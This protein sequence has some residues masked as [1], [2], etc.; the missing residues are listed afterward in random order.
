VSVARTDRRSVSIAIA[1]VLCILGIV[2][3]HAWTG[4]PGT[5][6]AQMHDTAQG[7]LRWTLIELVGRAAVPLLGAISGWL[8]AGSAA[9]RGWGAFMRGKLRAITVP[10]LAWN[11]IAM[12][13]VCG[14][15]LAGWIEAPLPVSA[16]WVVDELTA[17]ATPND[18]NVQM[19]FLRDLIVCMALAPLLARL[20]AAAVMA[21]VL[22]CAA[23]SVSGVDFPLLLR[24]SIMVFFALGMLVHRREPLAAAIAARAI[25]PSAALYLLLAALRVGAQVAVEDPARDWPMTVATFDLVMRT[26]ACVFFWQ[27]AWRL[28]GGRFAQTLQALEPYVFLTFCA[29]LVLIW[30]AAPAVGAM[31]GPLGAPLYPLFLILQPPLAMAG[32]FLIGR[33]LHA[34]SPALAGVLSGGRLADRPLARA[35]VRRHVTAR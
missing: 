26:V 11:A 30:L 6:L 12:V 28:A 5:Q 15:A 9:R 10:M 14:A 17:I 25:A 22:A 4:L 1:R 32:C 20:P 18:I 21:V 2:Y 23:W 3:V 35:P 19:P 29:H 34:L 7:M 27:L 24:P 8:A 33:G 31:T 16:W 13:L